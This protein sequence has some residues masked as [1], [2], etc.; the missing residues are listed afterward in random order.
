MSRE[1]FG[2]YVYNRFPTRIWRWC[3]TR[4]RHAA[5]Y[6]GG[7]KCVGASLG[8]GIARTVRGGPKCVGA[9]LGLGCAPCRTRVRGSARTRLVAFVLGPGPRHC[10]CARTRRVAARARDAVWVARGVV[11]FFALYILKYIL[12]RSQK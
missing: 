12:H 6:G 9:S 11:A 7:P 4:F 3:F 2:S 10:C 1:E 8:S 5:R